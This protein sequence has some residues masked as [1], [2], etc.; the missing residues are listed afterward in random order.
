MALFSTLV[1]P[2]EPMDKK[3]EQL[4]ELLTRAN[5][6][7][8][9]SNFKLAFK[10]YGR[11]IEFVDRK[12]LFKEFS[13]IECL[14]YIIFIHDNIAEM[15]YKQG[16]YRKAV[17]AYKVMMY[18]HGQ[19]GLDMTDHTVALTMIKLATVYALKKDGGNARIYYQFAIDA[20]EKRLSANAD[21]K[22]AL[23]L[24]RMA[25]EAFGRFLLHVGDYSEADRQLKRAIEV[26][27]EIYGDEH[28]HV[29][30]Y[31][32]IIITVNNVE[33]HFRIYKYIIFNSEVVV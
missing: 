25:T 10:L 7:H 8:E 23:F 9:R 16:D 24:L 1:S 27:R 11:A 14:N 33:P 18:S 12:K 28:P 5:E 26:C 6:E 32:I 20:E 30:P 21:D 17:E 29:G 2:A 19:L 3:T 13:D 15:A 4:A 31:S 22:Q